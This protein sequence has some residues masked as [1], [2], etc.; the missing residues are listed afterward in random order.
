MQNAYEE[1]CLLPAISEKPSPSGAAMRRGERG[2]LKHARE[3]FWHYWLPLLVMLTLINLESTDA[4]S[5]AHTGHILA[6]L[7]L[8]IGLP[9]RDEPLALLNLAVRK[10]GHMVGYGLLC[11]SWL[12]LLRGTYWLRHEYQLCL[13]GSIK[14]RRLWWRMEWGVLAVLCTF[15]V[16]AADE[17]HQMSIPSRTGCWSDVAL[18]TSAALV[19]AA[20]IWGRANWRCRQ[21]PA[22][23]AT[24]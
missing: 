19:A 6:Q 13:E 3:L 12:L 14:V 16:A 5:G 2:R 10:T 21:T 1:R 22:S 7:L 8:W 9:L 24:A 4:M 18:D 17:F 11:F 15:A 20:L 23:S